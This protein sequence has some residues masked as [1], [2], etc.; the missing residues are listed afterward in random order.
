MTR[1]FPDSGVLIEAAR[2]ATGLGAKL[3]LYYLAD[4][5][6]I[7]LTSAFV[8]LETV[9]KAAY[10]GRAAE[11]RFYEDFF[12]DRRTVWCRDWNRM[13]ELADEESQRIGLSA[14]DAIH[15][16]TAHLLGAD[17]LV[18]TESKK[19]AIHRTALVKVVSLY[20]VAL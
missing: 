17:E 19:K 4:P 13:L 20:N 12:R 7:Y 2:G 6:R 10:T 15:V 5:D 8:R 9:P 1:S 11:S 3:A 16:A 14:M 18:T